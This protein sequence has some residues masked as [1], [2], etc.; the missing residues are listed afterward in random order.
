MSPVKESPLEVGAS[1][2]GQ[3]ELNTV[4]SQGFH[5]LPTARPLLISQGPF[6][7]LGHRRQF[8]LAAIKRLFKPIKQVSGQ[9]ILLSLAAHAVDDLQRAAGAEDQY[10]RVGAEGPGRPGAAPHCAQPAVALSA[11]NVPAALLTCRSAPCLPPTDH[12][13]TGSSQRRPPRDCRHD[14]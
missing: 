14:L 5:N 7:N 10:V 2:S 8:P 9:F 4:V 6:Q 11:E 12:Q 1:N 13:L 3:Q